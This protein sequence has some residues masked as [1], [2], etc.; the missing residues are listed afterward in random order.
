M[1]FAF[2]L[3]LSLVQ[4]SR[5]HDGHSHDLKADSPLPGTSILQLGSVWKNQR[6][7]SVKL[8]DL[9]GK[10]RFVVVLYTRCDTACPLIVEDLKEIA[11]ELDPKK[12]GQVGVSVFS[13]DS[14]RETPQSL[15]DFS[16]K[17]KLP[18]HWD[19]LTSSPAAVSELAAALGVRYKRLK[20][21]EFIHSN[22]IF[23]LN[24]NGEIVARKEGLKTP[25]AEFM[26][27]V[28]KNL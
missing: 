11:T 28:R 2:F 13:L 5:A 24:R 27:Q 10:S 6:G 9:R 18:T 14:A 7:E 16:V 26:K 23:F 4:T 25:R 15:S 20:D 3:I 1:K 12:S 17:R 8:G 21:G 19:L 22:V